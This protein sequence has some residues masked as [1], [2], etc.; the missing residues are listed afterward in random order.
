[1]A[2]YSHIVRQFKD[3][4]SNNNVS[5]LFIDNSS[6]LSPMVLRSSFTPSC[7]SGGLESVLSFVVFPDIPSDLYT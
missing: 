4:H 7:F 1:M 6:T 3:R 2:N 5:L